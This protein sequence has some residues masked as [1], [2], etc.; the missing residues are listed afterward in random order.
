[1]STIKT[2]LWYYFRMPQLN[3]KHL[4]AAGV[5]L[6]LLLL[7]GAFALSGGNN[8]W[9]NT[10][11]PA[12]VPPTAPSENTAPAGT[13][14]EPEDQ[15]PEDPVFVPAS[16]CPDGQTLDKEGNCVK[17]VEQE[18]PAQL[19]TVDY[20]GLL[21]P[22]EEKVISDGHVL[23]DTEHNMTG[24]P[25]YSRVLE[26]KQGENLVASIGYL[27]D[28]GNWTEIKRF[29]STNVYGGS[30][31]YPHHV[32]YHG[33]FIKLDDPSYSGV[34][35]IFGVWLND[36]IRLNPRCSGYKSEEGRFKACVGD[37]LDPVVY[38]E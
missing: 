12:I 9:K 5:V 1:M 10:S 2:P 17:K 29:V 24:H 6:V 32:D 31:K 16:E 19:A 37:S 18:K 14:S 3:T 28:N 21:Y 23:W 25:L 7:L 33:T 13:I 35:L 8:T 36:P 30:E 15:I 38:T 27:N 26:Y 4:I 34:G 20:T 22:Y 11:V